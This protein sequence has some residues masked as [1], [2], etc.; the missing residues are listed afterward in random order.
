VYISKL[1][2]YCARDGAVREAKLEF[3]GLEVYEKEIRKAYRPKGLLA[4]TTTA[5]EYVRIL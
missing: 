2:A 3:S 5:K 4:S 1:K